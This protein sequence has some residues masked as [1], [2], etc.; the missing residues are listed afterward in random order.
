M[1]EKF[2]LFR[3]FR[4]KKWLTYSPH[5]R[6][7][8][9]QQFENYFAKKQSRQRL[10]VSWKEE[11]DMNGAYGLCQYEQKRI[12]LTAELFRNGY[13]MFL[14]M[15]TLLHECRHAF[16]HAYVNSEYENKSRIF[17][18]SKT[19]KW[20]NA[21][22]GYLSAT[23]GEADY[24]DYANQSIELDA[25]LYAY[26]Q[27]QKMKRRYATINEYAEEIE[28]LRDWFETVENL[29]K[30]KYGIFYK[31]KIHRKNKKQYKKNRK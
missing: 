21:L 20:K 29:G 16:Q 11:K 6:L 19:Y 27:L 5:K 25:N 15:S 23:N 13:K 17:K 26:K 31:F 2:K 14:L 28:R 10:I 4:F 22:G 8:Y 24:T 18:F 9:A 3:K 1:F 30:K 12:Y 7:E